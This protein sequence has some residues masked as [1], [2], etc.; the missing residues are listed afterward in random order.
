M[1]SPVLVLA[2]AVAGAG[3]VGATSFRGGATSVAR[4]SCT[5]WLASADQR[6]AA[7]R[8]RPL[9]PKLWRGLRAPGM[10]LAVAVRGKIVWSIGCGLR[11]LGHRLPVKRTTRFRTG[12]V[13]KTLTSAALAELVDEGKIDLDAS[14]RRYVRAF[15]HGVTIRQLAAHTAGLRANNADELVNRRHYAHVADTLPI[16]AHDPLLFAPGT[17]YSYSNWGYVLLGAALENAANLSYEEV[18]R[19]RILSP[20][21]LRRTVLEDVTRPAAGRATFYEITNAGR[22]VRA[23]DHDVS[24]RWPSAGWLSTA[25]EL[26]HFASAFANGQLVRPATVLAFTAEQHVGGRGTGYGLGWEV[27]GP[28]A[29]H[30]GNVVGGSALVLVHVPSATALALT[31]NIGF[32]T[33]AVPPSPRPGT[34]EPPRLLAPFIGG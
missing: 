22:A 24:F 17:D 14:V 6:A 21:G 16:F 5:Q 1:R 31:T 20:L 26:A 27:R 13:S 2:A 9:V 19:G 34:P 18:V 29:G 11:D 12:S 15:P 23:P 32:V 7:A 4:A 30:T 33:A 8:V 10:T 25:D 3:T 28:Y